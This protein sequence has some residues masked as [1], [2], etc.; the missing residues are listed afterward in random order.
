MAQL[1][2]LATVISTGANL[3]ATG[4][5]VAS[6]QA[7]QRAARDQEA[8]RQEQLRIAQDS[9]ARARQEQV[10]RTIASVRA[11][12]AAG[13]VRP[14]EGSGAAVTDGLAEDAR[15]AQAESDAIFASRLAAG[16]RS[17][18]NYDG[19]LAAWLRNGSRFATG[20]QSLLRVPR[21]P[22]AD[23]SD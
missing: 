20:V 10:R 5:Q 18:L 13:G 22:G 14:D 9:D 15:A 17:L 19:S 1:A 4:R 2:S 16:R 12:L 3:Y 11:R 6:Q 23:L 8:T 21:G 7:A